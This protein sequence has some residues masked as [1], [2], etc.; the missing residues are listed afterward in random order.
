MSSKVNARL[1]A[2]DGCAKAVPQQQNNVIAKI[3]PDMRFSNVRP[4]SLA[5]PSRMQPSA[6]TDRRYRRVGFRR[7]PFAEK[8][9]F[10]AA[11]VYDRRMQSSQTTDYADY[12][13]RSF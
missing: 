3:F 1:A 13:D 11:A 2:G 4:Q 7:A 9:S 5:I 10:V 12:T 8:A 6:V